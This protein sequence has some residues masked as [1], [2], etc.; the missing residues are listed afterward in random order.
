MCFWGGWLLLGWVNSVYVCVC[1]CVCGGP[2]ELCKQPPF[3]SPLSATVGSRS[4]PEDKPC[5]SLASPW[6]HKY[7]M[8][9]WLL[10]VVLTQRF[11]YPW[12]SNSYTAI[13]Y[14]EHGRDSHTVNQWVLQ[15]NEFPQ[16]GGFSAG[17][18]D[19]S[20]L[21]PLRW[22]ICTMYI[23]SYNSIV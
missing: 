11:A 22:A 18:L 16:H 23:I 20:L 17:Q 21:H 3:P 8:N 5:C 6:P 9:P 13:R 12:H 15:G 4:R 19:L 2:T 7:L 14:P 10:F 1:V